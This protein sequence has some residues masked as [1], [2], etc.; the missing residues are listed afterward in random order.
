MRSLSFQ[1][2]REGV[3]HDY[4]VFRYGAHV[5]QPHLKAE[6][7]PPRRTPRAAMSHPGK[8]AHG[9]QNFPDLRNHAYLGYRGYS[10]CPL[11]YALIRGEEVWAWRPAL[12][13]V[14]FPGL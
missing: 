12:T 10:G 13:P 7:V 9:A 8:A 6:S 4:K 11:W 14:G 5:L 3:D 1:V 2:S